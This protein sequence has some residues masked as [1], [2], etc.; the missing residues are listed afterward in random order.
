MAGENEIKEV[1]KSVLK[2][3]KYDLYEGTVSA[4]NKDEHSVTVE[5]DEGL[6]LEDIRL[7]AASDGDNTG[8]IV[9]PKLG[10]YVVFAQVR[11]EADYVLLKTTA[12]EEIVIEIESSLTADIPTIT[13]KSESIKA[14]ANE[15]ILNG[16]ENMGMVKVKELTQKLNAL[17]K[18]LNTIKAAF[19]AWLP[20]VGDMAEGLRGAAAAWAGSIIRPTA[21]ADIEND[22]VQH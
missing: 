5:I 18:D 8:V 15:I 20:A 21:Q 14:D 10:S 16:G 17:E 12:V 6:A 1:L 22:K 7:R 19:T 3:D 2:S 9:W 4:I 13:I 11:G